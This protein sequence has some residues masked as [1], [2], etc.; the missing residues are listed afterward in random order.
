LED[1]DF[2]C[3]PAPVGHGRADG[4]RWADNGLAFQAY[5]DQVLVPELREGDVVVMDNLASHKRRRRARSDRGCRRK[6]PYL[7]PY[8]PDFN[9]IENAFS[10]LKRCCATA[11]ERT[12]E[13]L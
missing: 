13:A 4:S 9:P 11:A 6:A 7:S 2:R 12:V 5:V 3:R 1:D 10:K 8:S